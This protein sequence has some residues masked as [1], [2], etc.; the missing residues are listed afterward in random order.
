[1]LYTFYIL[2]D[3]GLVSGIVESNFDFSTAPFGYVPYR[4]TGTCALGSEVIDD[5][6]RCIDIVLGETGKTS[7]EF[8][9]AIGARSDDR[10][11]GEVL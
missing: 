11:F 8:V 9:R 5:F 10:I 3:S 6:W 7:N 4:M 2:T 1:M